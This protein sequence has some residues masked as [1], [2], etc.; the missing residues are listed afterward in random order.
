MYM[1]DIRSL[2][3]PMTQDIALTNMEM[4]VRDGINR[5]SQ[6]LGA[7]FVLCALTLVNSEAAIALPW[8]FHSVL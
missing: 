7:T 1:A 6:S 4:L 2:P 5:D 3:M 8:L